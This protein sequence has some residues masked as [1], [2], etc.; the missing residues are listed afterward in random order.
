MTEIVPE[1]SLYAFRFAIMLS[2]F[3]ALL[4]SCGEGIRLFPFPEEFSP[5][6]NAKFKNGGGFDYQKNIHRF[7]NK[8]GNNQLK[9]KRDSDEFSA[10]GFNAPFA[11]TKFAALDLSD[12]NSFFN[13]A[14][15][16]SRLLPASL[17]SRAP[18]VS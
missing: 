10:K 15:L 4:F 5:N 14:R 8:Q 9:V 17:K 16:K 11:V 7:E 6:Q 2:V 13:S 1:K 18:P 3:A 12:K